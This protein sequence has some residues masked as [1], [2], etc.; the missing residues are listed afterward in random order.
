MADLSNAPQF[1]VM[2]PAGGAGAHGAEVAFNGQA[3]RNVLSVE[4]ENVAMVD[5]LVRSRIT[6]DLIGEPVIVETGG[7]GSKV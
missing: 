6:I 3:I 7:G 2:V 1:R 4:V 5:D